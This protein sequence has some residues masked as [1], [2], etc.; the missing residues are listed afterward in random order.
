MLHVTNGDSAA[1]TLRETGLEGDVLA[2]R[3]AL[4]EGPV[5]NVPRRELLAA[6][7]AFLGV[8]ASQLEERD[9]RL[10]EAE[11]VVLW[12]EHDLYDQLQL[13]D[14]LSLRADVELIVVGASLGPMSAE[15]LEAL[16]PQRVPASA[17]VVAAAAEA[18]DAVRAPEP[19]GLLRGVP[20]LPF[21]GPALRRFLEELPSTHDGLSRT[22]RA[23]L[24][25]MGEFG[26]AQAL[27][28]A[29]F[30]GDTWFWRTLDE[31][32]PL[33]EDE[34]LRRAVLAGEADRVELLGID[35][36]IGGTH[37]TPENLWRWD[38]ARPVRTR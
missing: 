20:Q 4:H 2:W 5:P 25:T 26:A 6:R 18:W 22:E 15:Q 24:Q 36:W 21:L 34:S 33:L 14:V 31:L 13:L 1:R 35:R 12:F 27:E 19:T 37:V 11:R 30:L 7:A 9:T 8:P 17:E 3:D 28:E 29:P 32:R 16:W 10:V 23:A 38:G